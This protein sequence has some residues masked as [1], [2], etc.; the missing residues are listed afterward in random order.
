MGLRHDR[1][2]LDAGYPIAGG[3]RLRPHYFCVRLLAV[4]T[5]LA[6]AFASP[7]AL[8]DF[9]SEYEARLAAA[10]V[11]FTTG[12]S[13]SIWAEVLRLEYG[14]RPFSEANVRNNCLIKFTTYFDNPDKP[15]F[16][17]P[18]L[19]VLLH[20]YSDHPDV[21]P[22]L[23]ADVKAALLA[24][25]FWP[26]EMA[27]PGFPAT[28]GNY[29]MGSWTE[30]HHIGFATGGY[31]AGQLYPDDTFTASGLTGREMVVLYRERVMRW[32]DFR[33]RTGFS[34]WMSDTYYNI[35][36]RAMLALIECAHDEAIFRKTRLVLNAFFLDMAL[37]T[38]RGMLASSKGRAYENNK[39]WYANESTGTLVTTLFGEG[40]RTGGDGS[41][42]MLALCSKYQ[43]PEVIYEIAVAYKAGPF[44]S[45]QRLGYPLADANPVYGLQHDDYEDV[46]FMLTMESYL[47]PLN[48]R[49]FTEMMTLYNWWENSELAPIA[50]F[51]DF[52]LF[53]YSTNT[54]VP[55]ATLYEYDIA[56][57]CREQAGVCTY[58][59]PDYM[60][61]S[62][63]DYK[64]GMGG[65]QHSVW[66]ATLGP[67]AVCFT[68]HP[69]SLANDSA[70]TPGFWTGSGYLPRVGQIENVAIIIYDARPPFGTIPIVQG[71][72]IV[73]FDQGP[74]VEGMMEGVYFP[75]TFNYTHAWLPKDQFDEVHEE[76]GWVFVRYGNGYM[77][78]RSQNPYEWRSSAAGGIDAENIDREMVVAG[79]QNVYLC[80]MGDAT[81][82]GTFA[83]FVNAILAAPLAFSNLSVA[84]TSPSQGELA[85]AWDGNLVR[86]GQPV[87]LG[88]YPRYENPAVV[89]ANFPCDELNLAYN[90]KTVNMDYHTG[91]VK[92][93]I[94]PP[95][96]VAAGAKWS[97]NGDRWHDSGDTVTDLPVGEYTVIFGEAFRWTAPENRTV[98]AIQD[99]T[100]QETGEYVPS[101]F[102]L[103]TSVVGSGFVS[104]NPPGSTH[105]RGTVVTVTANASSGWRFHHW[106]GALTGATN[107]A[108]LTMD[109][110]KVV[111][112]VFTAA[113][114]LD[115]SV[116][117]GGAVALDPAGGAYDRFTNVTLTANASPGWQFD[118]WTGAL[119]GAANPATLLMDSD[120]VV[121]AVFTDAPK[122][123]LST[124]VSG[125]GQITLDPDGG[126]Y[127]AGTVVT[128]RA[129]PG[130]NATFE[131]WEGSLTGNANPAQVTMDWHKSVTAVFTGGGGGVVGDGRKSA[132]EVLGTN[133]RE[134][135]LPLDIAGAP[136]GTVSP[137]GRLAVRLT[138]VE[139]I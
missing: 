53:M 9:Q 80:E 75:F 60:L 111:T 49:S 136:A 103:E 39:Q 34:E 88:G 26:D 65:D 122:Y 76:S 123:A 18:G 120:K 29:T 135:V 27:D 48:V 79:R 2:G 1:L 38:H 20:D 40:T 104:T 62:A 105:D 71:G 56:R 47:H 85:F 86:N 4:V 36:V 23:L 13:T 6:G 124:W 114:A 87:A 133:I 32:L 121:T 127:D 84:Y 77:A 11:D 10:V 95:A 63:Q 94:T 99:T 81:T 14:G 22:Q 96:A 24:F 51:K 91:A 118:H 102:T 117:G 73:G 45:K 126:S 137:T 129:I 16:Q 15:D 132:L 89:A 30:N 52:I 70:S 42:A 54:L 131:R 82:Y 64:K 83:N 19:M 17:I 128:V 116:Q 41:T 125:D 109:S 67:N 78:F 3:T 72:E 33:F 90:S 28:M 55:F 57:N 61:S 119:T 5:I 106:A 139:P 134:E 68:T 138:G 7:L 93:T 8:A 101:M 108:T 46:F 97:L 25:P 92:V 59:T 12:G 31:L 66:Q 130:P 107:P 100:T 98:T 69:A 112:A 50:A 35:D 21:S 37:N 110:D 74:W 44:L 43:L 115:V 58:R 113:Y